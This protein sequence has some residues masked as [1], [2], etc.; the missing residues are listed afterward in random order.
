MLAIG[1]HHEG[2]FFAYQEIL[3]H[4]APTSMAQSAI[5]HECLYGLDCLFATQRH[6]DALACREPVCLDHNRQVAPNHMAQGIVGVIE[7]VPSGGR[8]VRGL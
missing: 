4:H 3:Y 1:D 5:H 2:R 8:N 7:N 6:N